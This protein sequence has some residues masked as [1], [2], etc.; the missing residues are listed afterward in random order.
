VPEHAP[1]ATAAAHYFRHGAP[2]RVPAPLDELALTMF[3]AALQLK[4]L[5]RRC[6]LSTLL[7]AGLLDAL[8]DGEA[9]EVGDGP[10]ELVPL[11]PSAVPPPPLI[12]M[13]LLGK[14]RPYFGKGTKNDEL[15][16]RNWKLY[17][18]AAVRSH[19]MEQIVS[20]LATPNP[21]K[22]NAVLKLPIVY[23]TDVAMQI[24]NRATESNPCALWRC[25]VVDITKH[26][27]DA[28]ITPNRANGCNVA[29]A[30]IKFDHDDSTMIVLFVR[31][32][33]SLLDEWRRLPTPR[34]PLRI[35]HLSP[36]RVVSL[37]SS[38]PDRRCFT[39]TNIPLKPIAAARAQDIVEGPVDAPADVEAPAAA[40]PAQ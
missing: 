5:Q 19:L 21:E 24:A 36:M 10:V 18:S 2:G 16:I 17:A 27:V 33:P 13:A 1:L 31:E 39:V 7:D 29:L 38:M 4:L 8:V 32:I 25:S 26:H 40:N 11:D 9:F 12:P 34:Q 14:T 30:T 15:R 6:G 28:D 22:Q 3:K 23:A 20:L 37:P 35:H